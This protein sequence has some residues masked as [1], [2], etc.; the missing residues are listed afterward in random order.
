MPTDE[1]TP[2]PDNGK[3]ADAPGVR[4]FDILSPAADAPAAPND[5]PPQS[6]RRPHATAKPGA[7][8]NAP[9]KPPSTWAM[10]LEGT[11]QSPGEAPTLAAPAAPA[12]IDRKTP[13]PLG[14]GK[15]SP[16]IA[17]PPPAAPVPPGLPER[18]QPPAPEAVQMASFS[19]EG[20]AT[21]AKAKPRTGR[22]ISII[23]LLL[24]IAGIAYG[25]WSR[26]HSRV[27][28]AV[29]VRVLSPKPAAVYRWFSGRGT[30]TDHEGRTLSF[31][32][33]G[34][35]GRAAAAGNGVRGGRHP[36]PAARRA[37]RS[38]RC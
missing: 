3:P 21:A 14:L 30:V 33:A 20:A 24:A 7:A 37:H 18:R 15:A 13:P 35:P 22:V 34:D 28:Q 38:R 11:L 29:R 10:D 6:R 1:A 9:A 27:P 36:G 2:P 12:G 5:V 8:A 25:L 26:E 16:V 4:L 17:A 19:T 31:D 32:S 23:V